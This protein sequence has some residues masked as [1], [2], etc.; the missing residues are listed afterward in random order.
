VH[1]SVGI[2]TSKNS[3]CLVI[4]ESHHRQWEWYLESTSEK[5]KAGVGEIPQWL[6]A[7]A[8]LPEDSDSI[9]SPHMAI[10]NSL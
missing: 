5:Q 3:K 1:G 7:L 9:P 4:T 6:R 10:Y 2:R 8:T